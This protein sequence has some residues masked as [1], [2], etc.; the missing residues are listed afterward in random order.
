MITITQEKFTILET[1]IIVYSCG[2]TTG[3]AGIVLAHEMLH[4]RSAKNKLLGTA[5]IHLTSYPHFKLQHLYGHHP[6]VATD[7][8]YSSAQHGQSLYNFLFRSIVLGGLSTL[9]RECTRSLKLSNRKFHPRHN[10]LISLWLIQFIIYILILSLL[11]PLAVAAF[12]A[13]GVIAI[14]V[15]ETVNYIQHY[16]LNRSKHSRHPDYSCSWDN[17][18]VT[19]YALFNLGHHSDHHVHP[20]KPFYTLNQH[21]DAPRIPYGYFT[22]SLI[23]VLPTFWHS[24][25]NNHVLLHTTKKYS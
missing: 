3:I 5:L 13:Q 22:L 4:Q 8:D 16:G 14:F 18:S 15:L 17:Y 25:M 11:T 20:A 21:N 24:L 2:L 1:I 23:A 19:N 7:D 9:K 6:N 10:R 12:I